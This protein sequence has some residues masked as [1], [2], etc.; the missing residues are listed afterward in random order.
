MGVG[1]WVTLTLIAAFIFLIAKLMRRS[2]D[3]AALEEREAIQRKQAEA[4]ARAAETDRQTLG[5]MADASSD[6]VHDTAAAA[7]ERMRKRDPRTR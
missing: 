4:A 6:A 3:H 2:G 1:F 5:R 7:R